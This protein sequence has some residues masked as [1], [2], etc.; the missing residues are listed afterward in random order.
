V[1][2]NLFLRWAL[3]GRFYQAGVWNKGACQRRERVPHLLALLARAL[4]CFFALLFCFDI[5]ERL[6]RPFKS[7][8]HDAVCSA[9]LVRY[10]L[11]TWPHTCRTFRGCIAINQ[12]TQPTLLCP[13]LPSP[14]RST[15]KRT[16]PWRTTVSNSALRLQPSRPP[17]PPFFQDDVDIQQD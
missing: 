15:R 4:S 12:S 10:P 6:N 13:S 7:T 8:V 1:F 11:R 9:W 14:S 2:S 17:Y 3:D 16:P 5:P